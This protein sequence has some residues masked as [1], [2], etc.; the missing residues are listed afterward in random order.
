MLASLM[1]GGLFGVA[2]V[3]LAGQPGFG[4]LINPSRYPWELWVIALA[5]TVATTAG[6]LDWRYHRTAGIR[7]GPNEHR[8]ELLALAG[9]GLPLFLLMCAASVARQSRAFLLPVLVVLLWTVVLI[10]YD[11]FVFHRRRCDGHEALLHRT[12]LAGHCAAFLA[13]AHFCFVREVFHG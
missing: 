9:G 4:W 2:L 6:V 5:G 10:C 12:L 3:F 8:A 1:P 7:V 11:E 13:W